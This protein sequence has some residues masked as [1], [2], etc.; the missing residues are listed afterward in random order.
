MHR[1]ILYTYPANIIKDPKW[2]TDC[3]NIGNREPSEVPLPKVGNFN[4]R[5]KTSN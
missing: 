1:H 5:K 4:M 3:L 2:G